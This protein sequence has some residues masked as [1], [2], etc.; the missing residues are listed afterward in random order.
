MASKPQEEEQKLVRLFSQLQA[1]GEDGE[2][3]RGLKITEKILSLSP[4]D[5]D[6]LHCKIVCLVHSSK[7]AEALKLIE[8]L[9]RKGGGQG[10]D[11]VRSYHF[12]K[13]YCLYRLERYEESRKTL[14]SLPREEERVR[15][16]LAQ[17]A[18]RLEDYDRA[19]VVYSPLVRERSDE[20]DSERKANYAAALALGGQGREQA[21]G[22]ESLPGETMEQC[23][24]K[25]CCLLAMGRRRE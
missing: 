14:E 5:P 24:N 16:L 9:S 13:A 1:A 8:T 6:A 7:F 18:Y 22:I 12:E 17:I 21:A 15:E 25:A 3:E 11:A 19:S 4:N 2:Y 20:F 23:F 10:K